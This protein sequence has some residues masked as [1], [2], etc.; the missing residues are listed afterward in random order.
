MYKM[1]YF[2]KTNFQKSP[3]TGGSPSSAPLYLRFWWPEVA[4]F[5]QFVVFRTNYDETE[6]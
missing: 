6:L 1:Y 3:N 2:S 5:G 4:C